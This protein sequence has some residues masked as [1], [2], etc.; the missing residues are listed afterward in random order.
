[1]TNVRI[2]GRTIDINFARIVYCCRVCGSELK[3][4]DAGL[5]CIANPEHRRFIHRD[6]L[7]GIKN[8]QQ[9]NIEALTK[10]YQIVDGQV[11]IKE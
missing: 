9:E 7:A 8:K 11:V 4:R 5:V 3:K 10:F 2:D 6:E 1:M